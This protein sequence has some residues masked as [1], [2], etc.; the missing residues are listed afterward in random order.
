MRWFSAAT[1]LWV[2][3]ALPVVS[4][5]QEPA[6]ASASPGFYQQA[7]WAK[8]GKSFIVTASQNKQ[9]H[10]YR[11]RLDATPPTQLT[12]GVDSWPSWSP[13]NRRIAYRSENAGHASVFVALADGSK[14]TALTTLEDDNAWPAWS[15]SGQWI[16]F[17]AK[18]GGYFRVHLI[19]PDGSGLKPIGA[20][21]ANEMNPAW[22]RDGKRL[23]YFAHEEDS[24]WIYTID[25]DGSHRQRLSKGV[26]PTWA[27]RSDRILFARDNTV[28]SIAADGSDERV[29]IV[30][31]FWAEYSPDDEQVVF[32][33][34]AWPKSGLFLADTDGHEIRQLTP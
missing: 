10:L 33:R 27:K 16:A 15:P 22:S 9:W 20:Q 26:F 34:G 19:H 3:V 11:L 12:Q 25:S 21:G 17:S 13:D 8:D 1:S 24:D 18:V 31:A 28:Y 32:A 6:P 23:S 14:A 4:F 29:F 2:F 30:N 7:S 5:A